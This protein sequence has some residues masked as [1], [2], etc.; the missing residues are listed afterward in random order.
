MREVAYRGTGPCLEC[1][2]VTRLCYSLPL[3]SE[4]VL[5][6]T[7]TEENDTIPNDY[8]NTTMLYCM[9]VL[10]NTGALSGILSER[11]RTVYRYKGF[12][13]ACCGDDISALEVIINAWME[14][15]HPRIRHM[16]QSVRGEHI[17]LSFVYEDTRELEQR[18]AS[19][20]GVTGSF[21][22]FI[23]DDYRDDRPTSPHIPVTPP[24]MH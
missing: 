5:S 13:S 22:R 23:D 15:A 2:T 24:P 21:P 6:C 17:V 10:G 9:L 20:T 12:D 14:E 3:R 19:Q 1:G 16:C 8:T 7:Y 11:E 4:I 18:I